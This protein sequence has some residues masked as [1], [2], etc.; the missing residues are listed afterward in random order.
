M[1]NAFNPVRLNYLMPYGKRYPQ[2]Q[3]GSQYLGTPM[4]G[5]DSLNG[6]Q[7]GMPGG[8]QGYGQYG[9]PDAYQS[10]SQLQSQPYDLLGQDEMMPYRRRGMREYGR[11]R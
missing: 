3:Y 5:G 6:M 11:Y 2:P 4:F 10:Q 7:V 9:M 1:F 8:M